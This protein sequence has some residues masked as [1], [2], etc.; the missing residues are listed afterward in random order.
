MARHGFLMI[1]EG[2]GLREERLGSGRRERVGRV[3]RAAY[4]GTE[5]L[6]FL[7]RLFGGKPRLR[8]KLPFDEAGSD[9]LGLVTEAPAYRGVAEG[10]ARRAS[11]VVRP[12]APRENGDEIAVR[13]FWLVS[14]PVLRLVDAVH[15]GIESELDG[16][17]VAFA[18]SP[19]VIA[20]P[21]MRTLGEHLTRLPEE[22]VASVRAAIGHAFDTREGFVVEVREGD[23]LDVLGVPAQVDDVV[24]RFDLRGRT[25]SYR[26]ASRPVSLVLGDEPGLRMVMRV[27]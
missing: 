2:G 23:L 1:E 26:E 17:A 8:A 20:R 6:G 14:E 21:E 7:A 22:L 18:Q 3:E 16:A 12:L 24:R 15:L 9:V 25:T 19:L 27:R 13:D 4:F 5:R 11:G 10:E